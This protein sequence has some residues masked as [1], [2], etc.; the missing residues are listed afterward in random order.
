MNAQESVRIDKWLWAARICK[1]RSIATD[2]CDRGR[3]KIDE[4]PAK[5]SRKVRA[6]QLVTLR[7]GGITYRFRV[8]KG[9]DRR[10]GAKVA[11]ECREDLTPQEELDKLSVIR[12]G[13]VPYREPGTG[14]P[15]KR[16]RRQIERL[17]EQ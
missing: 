12:R 7:R 11:A 17:F 9:I 1:T 5:P 2:L 8:L 10:V 6:G 13:G 4:T 15:T 14:R 16:D 3:V